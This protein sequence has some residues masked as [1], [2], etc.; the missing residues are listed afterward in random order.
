[1]SKDSILQRNKEAAAR[2]IYDYLLYPAGAFFKGLWEVYTELVKS[3]T[4]AGRF[5]MMYIMT[6]AITFS[7]I[8]FMTYVFFPRFECS[9]SIRGN[10]ILSPC[11]SHGDCRDKWDK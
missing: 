4:P 2:L 8:G 1:M 5:A 9:I 7:F 6:M 11:P 3:L 10:E